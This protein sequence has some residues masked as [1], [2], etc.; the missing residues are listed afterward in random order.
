MLQC[1]GGCLSPLPTQVEERL[2]GGSLLQIRDLVTN[3]GNVPTTHVKIAQT[4]ATST[5][6]LHSFIYSFFAFLQCSIQYIGLGGIPLLLV[7]QPDSQVPNVHS[8]QLAAAVTPAEDN[9]DLYFAPGDT[10]R[11]TDTKCSL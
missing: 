8:D 11:L 4:K 5:C 10:A 7:T 2:T 9:V 6:A 3:P 1:E